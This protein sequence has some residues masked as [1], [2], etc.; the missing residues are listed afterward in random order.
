MN[1]PHKK[2]VISDCTGCAGWGSW[3]E[4]VSARLTL[5]RTPIRYLKTENAPELNHKMRLR[6]QHNWQVTSHNE[7]YGNVRFCRTVV[8]VDLANSVVYT[9]HCAESLGPGI[10]LLILTL[11][12]TIMQ[13]G[14]TTVML[15][16]MVQP[17]VPR[18][19]R[20]TL[21]RKS[22]T[23]RLAL[24]VSRIR[25]NRESYDGGSAVQGQ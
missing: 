23:L 1:Q 18:R 13:T 8:E 17:M 21:T 10:K 12:M 6:Q 2:K 5:L 25:P 3:S 9:L 16:A 4:L 15:Q 11:P 14:M 22:I 20:I 24:C 19:R 7:E